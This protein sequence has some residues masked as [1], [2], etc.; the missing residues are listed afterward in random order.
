MFIISEYETEE[1]RTKSGRCLVGKLMS[2]RRVYKEAL[3]AMMLRIW[4]TI[5]SVCFK[6]LHDNL[7]LLEFG[8]DSDK[9]RIKEERP[10]LFDR[11]VFVL[12]KLEENIPLAQMDFSHVLFWVQVHDMPLICMNKEIGT[13]IGESIGKV[14]DVDVTGDGVGW[15]RFLRIRVQV[16]ISKPLERGRALHLNGKSIWVSFKYE[17][18]PHFCYSCGRIVHGPFKC[19]KGINQPDSGGRG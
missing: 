13:R 6:E 11:R 10:W 15:G 19:Q 9:R 8:N 14:E 18:L 3:Q 1:L 12:K 4:K 7:W 16:D 17:K 5:E 2:E